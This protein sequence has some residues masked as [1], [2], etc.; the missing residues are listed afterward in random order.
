MRRARPEADSAYRTTPFVRA[1]PTSRRIAPYH[2]YVEA[3][4]AIE[5]VRSGRE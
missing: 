3:L 5:A 1:D 4:P 2:A